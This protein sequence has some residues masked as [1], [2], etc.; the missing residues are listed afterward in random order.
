MFGRT[1]APPAGT[2][3][4]PTHG[5]LSATLHKIASI[6][7]LPFAI[8]VLGLSAFFRHKHLAVQSHHNFAIFTSVI[9][10]V[11]LGYHYFHH[12]RTS[13]NPGAAVDKLL[14]V[15]GLADLLL[16]I[17]WLITWALYAHDMNRYYP[18]RNTYHSRFAATFALSLI[19]L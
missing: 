3:P 9:T 11:I 10:I 6:V 15:G 17:F 13:I 19:E 12:W 1:H 4:A 7:A 2:G 18:K 5:G 16:T 8:V 14:L